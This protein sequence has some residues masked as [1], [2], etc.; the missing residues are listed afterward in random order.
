MNRKGMWLVAALACALAAPV[1]TLSATSSSVPVGS[2]VTAIDLCPDGPG[3]VTYPGATAPAGCNG[4]SGGMTTMTVCR[5][6]NVHAFVRNELMVDGKRPA[7]VPLAGTVAVNVQSPTYGNTQNVFTDD[8]GTALAQLG[9]LPTG[10]Y[11]V[12]ASLWTGTRTNAEG[13]VVSYPSS[14]TTM[15][16]VVSEAP[17][18]EALSTGPGKRGCGAGDANHQHNPKS[19]KTCSTK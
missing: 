6:A 3:G 11:D 18:G 19:G 9:P 7:L 14:K 13:Q 10:T 16:L 12:S 8:A 15:Q 2:T 4:D 1:S 17:C 5:D